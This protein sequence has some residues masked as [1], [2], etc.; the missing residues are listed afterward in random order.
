[1]TLSWERLDSVVF[2]TKNLCDVREFYEGILELRIARYMKDGAEIEDV[3][4]RHVNY[5]IGQALIGFEA[6]QQTQ[7]G[8]LVLRVGDLGSARDLLSNRARLAKSR[9]FFVMLHDPD[10]R[11]IIIEQEI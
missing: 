10:G 4:D 3:T 7:I 8:E 2:E 1:M 11:C 9:D 5:R 6:G